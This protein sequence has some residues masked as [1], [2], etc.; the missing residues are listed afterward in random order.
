MTEPQ[1]NTPSEVMEL[2]KQYLEQQIPDELMVLGKEKIL[3]IA[4][5][6]IAAQYPQL[7]GPVVGSID[8]PKALHAIYIYTEKDTDI[9]FKQ[10][11]LIKKL[12]DQA[13]QQYEATQ[14]PPSGV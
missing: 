13:I 7:F 3:N 4:R 10:F 2:T 5:R 1:K 9:T 8:T 14:Q 12:V 11:T 6:I